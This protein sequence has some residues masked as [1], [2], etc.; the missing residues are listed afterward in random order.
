MGH[1]DIKTTMLYAHHV[2]RHDAAE[3]L[4]AAIEARHSPGTSRVSRMCRTGAFRP[5]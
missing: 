1:A 3:T 5:R 2:P 4:G